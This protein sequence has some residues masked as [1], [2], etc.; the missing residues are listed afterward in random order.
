MPAV[1]IIGGQWGD[2]GKGRTVDFHAR[3]C[4]TIVRYSAGTNAG[5]TI[6]NDKGKFGLHLVPAGIFYGDKTCIIGN[7]V[8]I[9]PATLFN[10]IATLNE[11][12]VDTSMLLVSERAHVIMP[13]HPIIDEA[14]EE[15]RG[16]AAI[17]TTHTGTGPAFWDKVQRSGVRVIDLVTPELLRARLEQILPYKN[18]VLTSLYG[19]DPLD[20]DTVFAE[21][22]EHG[23]RLRPYVADTM[24]VVQEAH[25][26]GE[27]ILL[28]GAQG[29]LLDLDSGTYPY[30]TSSVPA[31]VSA[32]AAIGTGLGL[33]AIDRVVGVY[34]AYQTRVGHGPMPTE[35]FD[36]TGDILREG[37]AGAPGTAE[38]GT[39]TGRP[40]RCGWFDGVLA[41]YTA[42]LNGV[43]SVALT[44]LD[45]LSGFESVK[46]CVAY[47]LDG[48]RVNTLPASLA[49]T[50][51]VQPIYE[52]LP[53][54]QSDVTEVRALGDLPT[55]ARQFVRR[56]EQILEAPI[57]MISVGP[58]R[59]QAIVT[60]DVFGGAL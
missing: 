18:R 22:S 12:D 31:S 50:E 32:G 40:R 58:E 13:W 14:D 30:V 20:F 9:D 8:V 45:S 43:T 60:R 51:R 19:R 46:I 48:E 38:Y 27:T 16:S 41:R 24:T 53:G 42:R 54:W 6:I 11:S 37:G 55:E 49:D 1:V 34:K 59:S 39:T 2:E 26:R 25:W 36:E 35:L 3:Y 33:T 17:G 5:H 21:A 44:R 52:E 56:I 29:T 23:D 47:E 57:D 4:S 15:L 7:G 28:E 10:E